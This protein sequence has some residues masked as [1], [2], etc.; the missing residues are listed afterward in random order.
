MR[1]KN[2]CESVAPKALSA[3]VLAAGLALAPSA[4]AQDEE[5]EVPSLDAGI[6]GRMVDGYSFS[7]LRLQYD[8]VHPELPLVE[9]L[10]SLRVDL[11]TT[12]DVIDVSPTSVGTTIGEV[13]GLRNR[14]IS[15][16]AIN[17]ISRAIVADLNRRG[18]VGVLVAPDPF[19]RHHAVAD[20]V[21]LN[22]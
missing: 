16:S 2:V 5:I 19:R 14:Q 17:E 20:D 13:L 3:L 22:G 21:V 11:D 4:F 12:G 6:A 1:V 7:S 15:I 8:R 9:S 10:Y 18:I